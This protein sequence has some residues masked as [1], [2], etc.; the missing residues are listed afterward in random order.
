MTV[1]DESF[2]VY[3]ASLSPQ[4]AE[5]ATTPQAGV[6]A[7]EAPPDTSAQPP[8]RDP[9]PEQPTEAPP[10]VPETSAPITPEQIQEISSDITEEL[11]DALTDENEKKKEPENISHSSSQSQHTSVQSGTSTANYKERSENALRARRS[12]RDVKLARIIDSARNR[13]SITNNEISK[14]L[15]ISDATATRYASILVLRGELFR[16]G[17]GRAIRYTPRP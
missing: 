10:V 4:A 8:S 3:P 9:L 2:P 16:S 14:L 7:S 15:H 11:V 17:K 12:K 13:G 6:A 1:P 5:P